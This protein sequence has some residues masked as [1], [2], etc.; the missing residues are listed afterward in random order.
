MAYQNSEKLE[1]SVILEKLFRV[2]DFI[3]QPNQKLG[4]RNLGK[5]FPR[6]LRF[7]T[8]P[9]CRPGLCKVIYKVIYVVT[10]GTFSV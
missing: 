5:Q 9:S 7:P 10:D 2:F 8:F 1:I 4:F 6:F 3:L